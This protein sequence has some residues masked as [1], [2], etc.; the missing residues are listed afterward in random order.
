MTTLEHRLYLN[1][2][3]WPMLP[4]ELDEVLVLQE[5]ALLNDLR[6][7]GEERPQVGQTLPY[8]S[9]PSPLI[10]FTAPHLCTHPPAGWSWGASTDRPSGA[11]SRGSWSPPGIQEWNQVWNH[12]IKMERIAP[13][14]GCRQSCDGERL[15]ESKGSVVHHS[16]C[17]VP[18]P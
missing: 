9:H 10:P 16:A 13:R 3:V 4:K 5:R 18:T 12:T 14:C 11:G 17:H 15:R 2:Q 6:R 8:A 1:V 7:G